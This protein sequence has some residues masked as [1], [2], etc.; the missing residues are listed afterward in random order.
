MSFTKSLTRD[1]ASGPLT[2]SARLS[3]LAE[4]TKPGITLMVVLTAGL[5]FLL[6]EEERISFL[7]LVHTLLGTG[8]VSAGASALNQVIERETDALMRRT[9]QR[10]LPA[11]RMD[12]DMALLFGVALGVAGLLELALAVNLLTALLGAVALAGYVFVYTPLKRLSS[13]ATIIGAV[14]GAIPPMMG[15]SAVRNDIDLAAWVLFGIL[16]FWQM[17]HFLAIAWLCR[18]DYREA[19][20]PMLTVS[21]PEGLRTSRQVLLYGAVLVPVSL[22]PSLLGLMGT[23]Y[24]VGALALGLAYFGFGLGFARSRTTPGA[25]WLMLASVLYFPA[26]LLVMLLDRVVS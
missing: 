13:L 7:L 22:M 15:W 17:P 3:D 8:L 1:P 11:G 19:G 9:S 23:V 10:P 21:D 5:G 16:F 2:L 26:V 24:F 25:R 20:F 12:P 14:P 18:D 6:A 4:L